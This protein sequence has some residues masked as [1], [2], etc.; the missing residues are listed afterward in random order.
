MG[1]R[2]C[3]C[4]KLRTPPQPKQRKLDKCC[5][6]KE[7]SPEWNDD[8]YF[9]HIFCVTCIPGRKKMGIFSANSSFQGLFCEKNGHFGKQH[10]PPTS[11]AS[12]K[13]FC[14]CAPP[15]PR[16]RI[17]GSAPG[18]MRLVLDGTRGIRVMGMI[19]LLSPSLLP[20]SA[21]VECSSSPSRALVRG[22]PLG[23]IKT[24]FWWGCFQASPSI[25]PPPLPYRHHSTPKTVHIITRTCIGVKAAGVMMGSAKSGYDGEDNHPPHQSETPWL[26]AAFSPHL[27]SFWCDRQP[28]CVRMSTSRVSC[29][30]DRCPQRGAAVRSRSGFCIAIWS[31]FVISFSRREGRSIQISIRDKIKRN[32]HEGNHDVRQLHTD[33]PW[34]NAPKESSRRA[35]IYRRLSRIVLGGENGFPRPGSREWIFFQ[36]STPRPPRPWLVV[37]ASGSGAKNPTKSSF[38]DSKSGYNWENW[39][40]ICD[41]FTFLV[42]ITQNEVGNREKNRQAKRAAKNF[43]IWVLKVKTHF[44][45]IFYDF[46]NDRLTHWNHLGLI[47]PKVEGIP[48]RP[49]TSADL[50]NP[51]VAP[52][53]LLDFSV[54]LGPNR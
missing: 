14:H 12:R 15:P 38:A 35:T 39:R 29:H 26:V 47:L 8:S 50:G 45:S 28:G 11:E 49:E 31:W 40:Q 18:P 30:L 51:G 32:D 53:R 23:T 19:F 46:R 13:F 48:Q 42:K 25:L 54:F 36:P 52:S 17:P 43:G 6:N 10:E 22:W 20:P 7:V 24:E 2:F 5:R 27:I 34:A 33:T 44:W 4:N 37:S 21:E 1:V 3:V 9:Q 16:K 41:I